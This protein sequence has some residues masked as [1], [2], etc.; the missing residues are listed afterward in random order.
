MLGARK[1]SSLIIKF[2]LHP[3]ITAK[4]FRFGGVPSEEGRQTVGE[5][6]NSRMEESWLNTDLT[7][8]C[9]SEVGSRKPLQILL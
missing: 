6:H 8:R 3:A 7:A 4:S 5:Q 2:S 9:I 1:S